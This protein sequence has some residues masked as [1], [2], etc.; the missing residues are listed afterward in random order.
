MH[1]ATKTCKDCGYSFAKTPVSK[2]SAASKKSAM[3]KKGA[4]SKKTRVTRTSA[5]S[6]GPFDSAIS[7]IRSAGG[8]SEARKLLDTIE[9]IKELP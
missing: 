8:I 7:Y 2:K 3:S 9:A 1:V 5:S 4:V 6:E